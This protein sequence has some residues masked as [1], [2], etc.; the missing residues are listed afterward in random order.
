MT[1][2]IPTEEQLFDYHL[3]QCDPELRREVL[4]YLNDHPGVA[5]RLEEYNRI[6]E[7][8]GQ[9]PLREPSELVLKRVCKRARRYARPQWFF[10]LKTVFV[11]RRLAWAAMILLVIGVGIVLTSLRESRQFTP[12]VSIGGPAIMAQKAQQTD[13]GSANFSGV[14]TEL[15][16]RSVDREQTTAELLK[17][18]AKGLSLYHQRRFRQ[19]NE[20]FSHIMTVNPQF[21]KRVELYT[22]WIDSL[23]QVGENKLAEE[24]RL[25]LKRIADQM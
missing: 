4:A 7:G 11:P 14:L 2:F 25:E 21:E 18:Y 22:H 10:G 19:A 6:E 1:R 5:R 15:A 17:E 9:F 24:K 16:L 23:D 20:I 3:G 12:G 13:S 8:F